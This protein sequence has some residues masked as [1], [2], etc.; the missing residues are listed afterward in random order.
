MTEKQKDKGQSAINRKVE[1]LPMLDSATLWI[2]DKNNKVN[3]EVRNSMPAV[4]NRN[5][6]DNGNNKDES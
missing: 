2:E 4:P 3:I 5:R 6:D 1:E